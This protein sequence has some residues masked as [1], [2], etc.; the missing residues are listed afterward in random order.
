MRVVFEVRGLCSL[1]REVVLA[2]GLLYL[3]S[4]A[5][6]NLSALFSEGFSELAQS[7]L[8]PINECI[9]TTPNVC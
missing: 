7:L 5:L 1:G 3:P 8:V 2:C 4:W 9:S 6:Q